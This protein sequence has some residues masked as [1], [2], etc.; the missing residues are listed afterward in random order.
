MPI[1]TCVECSAISPDK[2][3][4]KLAEIGWTR[5]KG[6]IDHKKYDI[7]TCPLCSH[8]FSDRLIKELTKLRQNG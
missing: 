6:Q 2:I 7:S 5:A 3:M 1:L 4:D 8:N